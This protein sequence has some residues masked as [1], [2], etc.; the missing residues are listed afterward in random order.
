M[1]SKEK[2]ATLFRMAPLEHNRLTRLLMLV[3]AALVV[4]LIALGS[5]KVM[6]RSSLRSCNYFG[7]SCPEDT[8]CVDYGDGWQRCSPTYCTWVRDCC[9]APPALVTYRNMWWNTALIQLQRLRGLL[10]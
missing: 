7:E 3:A 8:V 10:P 1:E 4:V 9:Q 2:H 6:C 5:A